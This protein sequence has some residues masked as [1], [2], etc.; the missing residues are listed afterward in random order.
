MARR[1]IGLA[2]AG[3]LCE[4]RFSSGEGRGEGAAGIWPASA[5]GGAGGFGVITMRLTIDQ[6]DPGRQGDGRGPG[7]LSAAPGEAANRSGVADSS[8]TP[9][10]RWAA[11]PST[12]VVSPP[13]GRV[14]SGEVRPR[15][16]ASAA[17]TGVRVPL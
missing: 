5:G 1:V 10:S 7:A 13:S 9:S 16:S 14:P 17:F 8:P 6:R 2:G 11:T 3:R 12:E 15:A 4:G